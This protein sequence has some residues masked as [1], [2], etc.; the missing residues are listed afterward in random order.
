MKIKRVIEEFITQIEQESGYTFTRPLDILYTGTN[1]IVLLSS[2]LCLK[3][4]KKQYSKAILNSFNIKCRN[5]CLPIQTYVSISGEYYGYIQTYLNLY[6]IQHIIKRKLQLSEIVAGKIIYDVLNGLN[7]LHDRDLLH[8]DLH[9]A[10]IMLH[11]KNKETVAVIIDFDEMQLLTTETKPCFRY[12]GYQAPE[13]VR[14]DSV[15][16]QKA[17]I[18]IVGVIFWELLYGECP[19]AGYDF[20]GKYIEVSWEYYR[21]HKTL[22]ESRIQNEILNIEEYKGCLN[23]LSPECAELLWGLINPDKH[24]R[25]FAKEALLTSF[26][27]KIM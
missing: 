11:S 22:I 20:F 14:N 27:Q 9:P 6:N 2:E 24:K 16:D 18:F 19:F 21:K 25:L 10:N 26:F 13:I 17:E 3:I 1:I 8:R 7:H 4:C 12:S 15:Y 5:L 23:S